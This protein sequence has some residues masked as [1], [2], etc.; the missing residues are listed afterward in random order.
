MAF[1]KPSFEYIID[2][3]YDHGLVLAGI[4][5]GNMDTNIIGVIPTDKHIELF[6]VDYNTIEATILNSRIEHNV[7]QINNF[8][9]LFSSKLIDIQQ[10][11]ALIILKAQINAY[12]YVFIISSIVVAVGSFAILAMK[13]KKENTN[14]KVHME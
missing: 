14:I 9:H 8:S 11:T 3:T 10:Y 4:K 1:M 7:L 13:I 5:N 6:K 2:K 12:D